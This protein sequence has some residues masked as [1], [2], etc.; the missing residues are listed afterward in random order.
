MKELIIEHFGEVQLQFEYFKQNWSNTYDLLYI[1]D[2]N[3]FKITA[4][5]KFNKCE[6]LEEYQISKDSYLE[7]LQD[8]IDVL[9]DE[10]GLYLTDTP[11]LTVKI[12]YDMVEIKTEKQLLE[13]LN[14]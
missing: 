11:K 2:K 6:D 12:Y 3:K 10:V 1:G 7:D 5:V 4:T 9:I 8:S 13:K 14:N